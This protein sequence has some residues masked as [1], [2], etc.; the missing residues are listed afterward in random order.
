MRVNKFLVGYTADEKNGVWCKSDYTSIAYN[1]GDDVENR[2]IEILKNCNNID[3]YS[4]ELKEHCTNWPQTY[5][6]SPERSNILRPFGEEFYG[7]D[8]L[9]IGGGCGAISRYLGE[10]GANLLTLEGSIRRAS[11]A[12]ERTR[13][14]DNVTIVADSFEGFNV[15]KKFD[16]VTLIGVL[17]YANVFSSDEN[18]IKYMLD[19]A[20]SFLR[21]N[22]KLIIA[23]ENRLGL[24]YFAGA[25]EDHIGTPMYGID[26]RYKSTE[27]ITFGKIELTNHLSASGFESIEFLAPFPD[28]KFPSFILTERAIKLSRFDSK[29]FPIL[30]SRRDPLLPRITNFNIERAWEY[31]DTNGLT[32]DLSNSFLCIGRLE[33]ADDD[34]GSP[35]AYSY[36]TNREKKFCKERRFFCNENEEIFTVVKFPFYDEKYKDHRSV[37]DL[38]T[39]EDTEYKSGELLILE[40]IKIVTD[41]DFC[42]E[43]L[44]S[45]FERYIKIIG[46]ESGI[47]YSQMSIN[48]LLP[49][50]LLDAIPQNIVVIGNEEYSIIDREWV[51]KAELE[52]GYLIFRSLISIINLITKI[53]KPEGAS[54]RTIRDFVFYSFSVIGLS[55]DEEKYNS[56]VLREKKLRQSVTGCDKF[57]LSDEIQLVFKNAND[58][59]FENSVYEHHN[60]FEIID[61]SRLET[62]NLKVQVES[63][64]SSHD[65]II[66]KSRLETDNLKVQVESL[67]SSHDEIIDKYR[68]EN[69]DLKSQ[70]EN[71]KLSNYAINK[72]RELY[73]A[74]IERITGSL[75]WK[76][77]MPLRKIKSFISSQS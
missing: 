38:I 24:K 41:S 31:I 9:E 53:G 67:K 32:L 23:I 63:L 3:V 43:K 64:K 33:S 66:D 42:K 12:R 7:K 11:I 47:P 8:V 62:D 27:A 10:C 77:T 48:T 34:N 6:F 45:F 76:I 36:S 71:L 2:I 74:S 68:L 59:V 58:I 40:F 72:E 5:H 69:D 16:F 61:K 1:D 20:K 26:G 56:Y 44:V 51:Y 73:L 46:L 22:G 21:P 13:D 29:I 35:I 50:N 25:G 54:L 18:P 39:V 57:N 19:K 28:Y 30:S 4:S 17:E 70:V 37:V 55:L 60:L 75:S 14:L 49:G 15:E 65:E 52:L